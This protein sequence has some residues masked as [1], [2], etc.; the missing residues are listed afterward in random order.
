[1]RNNASQQLEALTKVIWI[2][3][4]AEKRTLNNAN[5]SVAF[6]VCNHCLNLRFESKLIERKKVA[7]S[8]ANLTE[9]TDQFGPE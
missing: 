9:N 5:E 8:F 2:K 6:R 7:K 1:M 3:G 4:A